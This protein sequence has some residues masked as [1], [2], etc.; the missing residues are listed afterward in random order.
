MTPAKKQ[1][2]NEAG[3]A[4]IKRFESLSLE[5]YLCPTGHLTIG[6]GHVGP[7]V[8]PE[9]ICSRQKAENLLRKDLERFEAGVAGLLTRRV[10]DNQFAA[11]VSLA[12]NVGPEA[13]MASR[14]MKRV[15]EGDPY[16]ANEFAK[17]NKGRINGVLKVLPGLTKRRAAE[18]ALY[19]QPD[20]RIGGRNVS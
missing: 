10:T 16:A 18:A 15:N 9:M 3:I 4:L 17:W 8:T 14:L 11:L 12:F 13:L 7:D 19:E 5:A 1:R 2:T 6:W 20:E